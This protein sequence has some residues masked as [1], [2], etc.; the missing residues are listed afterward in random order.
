VKLSVR[1]ST[2]GRSF[3]CVPNRPLHCV[4]PN[5]EY[6]RVVR[7]SHDIFQET[8]PACVGLIESILH[9]IHRI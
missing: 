8:L 1:K 3:S 9:S 6:S 5:D 7:K 2:R 4:I